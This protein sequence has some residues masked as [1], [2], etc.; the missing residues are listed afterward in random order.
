VDAE[1]SSTSDVT[2]EEPG[3]DSAGAAETDNRPIVTFKGNNYDLMS[4]AGV[5]VAGATLFTCGTCGFG[6]YCLPIVP[7]IFG[8][9]G[10]L[11]LK[12]SVDP[13]RTKQLSLVSIGVGSV[14]V[15]MV[16]AFFMFYAVYFAFI[17]F[18]IASE[19]GGF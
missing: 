2:D 11:S 16:L 4:V 3:T 17:F 14:F 12:E 7:I 6:F 13:H 1:N 18:V 5:S 9:I 10:L 15:L 8:A 19:G